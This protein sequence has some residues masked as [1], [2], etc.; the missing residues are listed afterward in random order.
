MI[1][2]W[3]HLP[4]SSA[5]T[6]AY[7]F[8]TPTRVTEFG[9]TPSCCIFWNTYSAFCPCPHF[10]SPNIMA[11]QL[12]TFLRLQLVK[13]SSSILNDPTFCIHLNQAIPHKDIRLT[14][15]LNDLFINL[16]TSFKCSQ[17]STLANHLNKSEFVRSHSLLLHLLEK[18]HHLLRL[19]MLHL[20]RK[21]LIPC[22]TVHL[23]CVWR[24]CSH[25][26][27]H[28]W[29]ILLVLP[30][31]SYVG[32][33]GA[34]CLATTGDPDQTDQPCNLHIPGI[35]VIIR[36]DWLYWPSPSVREF[37][38]SILHLLAFSS[39]L[40]LSHQCKR[41]LKNFCKSL[42]HGRIASKREQQDWHQPALWQLHWHVKCGRIDVTFSDLWSHHCEGSR[43]N[44][45]HHFSH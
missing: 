17:T 16:S 45:C 24:H 34:F 30:V 41:S 27:C 32:N 31:S 23:H 20:F 19:P 15:T 12:T 39:L 35:N 14:T 43:K 8:S 29:W 1:C 28:P 4:S 37:C 2:S 25:C 21:L 26:C 42:D 36:T 33:M 7:A 44:S 13:H 40:L 38:H 18:Q 10:T 22:K 9:C 5:T 11:V 6:L 3:T